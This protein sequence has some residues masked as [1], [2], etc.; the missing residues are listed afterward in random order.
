MS[1]SSFMRYIKILL[2]AIVFNVVISTTLL[3]CDGSI[4][5]AVADTVT[6]DQAI[7]KVKKNSKGKVLG[8]KTVQINGQPVHVIKVLTTKGRVKR[9]RIQT[10]PNQHK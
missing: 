4:V 6:L 10:A 2:L 5:L 1:P 3:A 9:I 7:N 8:A